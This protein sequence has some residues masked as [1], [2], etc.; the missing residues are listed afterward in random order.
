MVL[1]GFEKVWRIVE[2]KIFSG[3]RKYEKNGKAMYFW[4][5]GGFPYA[6]LTKPHGYAEND[7]IYDP[8]FRSSLRNDEFFGYGRND[9]MGYTPH[10]VCVPVP[11]VFAFYFFFVV[12]FSVFSCSGVLCGSVSS[13][14]YS[15]RRCIIPFG[16]HKAVY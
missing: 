9:P 11:S 2:N 6:S 12:L 15:K 4:W 3:T 14:A 16:N 8:A 1:P 7:N 13:S 5:K 10:H